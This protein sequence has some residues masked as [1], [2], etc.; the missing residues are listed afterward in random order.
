MPMEAQEVVVV[1]RN[2][3][4]WKKASEQEQLAALIA[5]DLKEFPGIVNSIQQPIENRVNELMSGARTD[6]VVKLF[7]PNLD[8]LV[9]KG[10]AIIRI[11][12][13]IN[14]AEMF[15]KIKY[16]VYRKSTSDIT[17]GPWPFMV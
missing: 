7:G 9:V 13:K 5:E 2:K 1:L 4:D 11:I 10:N 14:G 12:K 6:V 16:L 3:E 17:E 15:R 8:T